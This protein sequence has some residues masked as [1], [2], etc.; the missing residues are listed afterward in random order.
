MSASEEVIYHA[1]APVKEGI[2]AG[3]IGAGVGLL[4]SAVQNSVGSHSQGAIGVFT[5]T[6]HTIGVFGNLLSLSRLRHP[7]NAFFVPCCSLSGAGVAYQ[8]QTRTR[9]LS[10]IHLVPRRYGP[11]LHPQ[12]INKDGSCMTDHCNSW[13]HYWIRG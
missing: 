10:T 7:S 2:Q 12:R 6:G 5:R 3:A 9:M 11:E 4:V 13:E 8:T 1:K